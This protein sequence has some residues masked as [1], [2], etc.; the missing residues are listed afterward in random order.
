MSSIIQ[1]KQDFLFVW[2]LTEM[3][4]CSTTDKMEYDPVKKL[5]DSDLWD[6]MT[7]S[8]DEAL[9]QLREYFECMPAIRELN[10]HF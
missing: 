7:A 4:V 10:K 8:Q 5:F 1:K 3:K 2:K 9:I 6:E